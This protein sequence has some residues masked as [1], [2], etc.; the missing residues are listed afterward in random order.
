MGGQNKH[1]LWES[2]VNTGKYL[3]VG[4]GAYFLYF[5]GPKI[6]ILWDQW[7]GIK[8]SES[9]IRLKWPFSFAHLFFTF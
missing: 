8:F 5:F 6:I 4:T 9:I 1:G 3:P 7:I 2:N